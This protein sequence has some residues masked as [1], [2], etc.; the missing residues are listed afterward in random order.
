M[1]LSVT[2]D[3]VSARELF[4]ANLADGLGCGDAFLCSAIGVLCPNVL[5][6]VGLVGSSLGAEGALDGLQALVFFSG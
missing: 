5:V 1:V 3:V 6:H 2:Q 4:K